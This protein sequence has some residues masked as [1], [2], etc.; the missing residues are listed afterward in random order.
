MIDRAWFLGLAGMLVVIAGCAPGGSREISGISVEPELGRRPVAAARGSVPLVVSPPQAFR[1]AALRGR[2]TEP[3]RVVPPASGPLVRPVSE[4]GPDVAEIRDTFA[5]YRRAFNRR[6][7]TALAAYWSEAGRN[8]DLTS[9]EVT[10]GREAVGAVFASLFAADEGAAI[11]IEVRSIRPVAADVAVVDGESRIS[12]GDGEAAAGRFSAVVVRREGRWLLESVSES[13]LPVAAVR[14][15]LADLA[16]LAGS[17]EDVGEGLTASTRC[18]WSTGEGFLIRAHTVTADDAAR[19]VPQPGD[20]RI[21]GLLPTG[22]ASRELTEIIGWD[23]ERQAIRSWLFTSDGRFAESTWTRDGE[24]WLVRTEGRG[25]D[26]GRS[27]E[28][29]VVRLGPDEIS[30]RAAGDALANLLPPAADFIRTAR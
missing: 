11:D 29:R 27:A 4:T 3:R 16:W 13:S 1:M 6:N 8:I 2:N 14:K 12:F 20:D 9:G 26:E 10:T 15:P 19:A 24:S 28:C 5:G 17:W 23:P 21:P 30:V 25:A 7:A 18:F 22:Y